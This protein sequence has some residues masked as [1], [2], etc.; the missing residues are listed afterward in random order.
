MFCY[1][2]L[3][4]IVSIQL[5]PFYRTILKVSNFVLEVSYNWL[6]T[7]SGEAFPRTYFALIGQMTQ[8]FVI[9]LP[10]TACDGN[11]I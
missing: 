7:E 10:L 8:S 9:G 1:I 5:Y 11:K 2:L 6:L 4:R 3:Y